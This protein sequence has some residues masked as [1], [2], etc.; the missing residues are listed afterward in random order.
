MTSEMA[1]QLSD[2]PADGFVR[3]HTEHSDW[4][5]PEVRYLRRDRPGRREPVPLRLHRPDD[6]EEVVLAM[7]NIHVRIHADEDCIRIALSETPHRPR[8]A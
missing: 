5:E 8:A 7:G 1:I 3:I 4:D 2:G 6:N